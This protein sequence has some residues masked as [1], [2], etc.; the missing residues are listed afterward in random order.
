MNL[1]DIPNFG[2]GKDVN[3]YVKHILALVHGGILWMD[4]HVSIDVDF[5]AEII[6]LPIDGEKPEHYL[7]DITK[8]KT[9]GE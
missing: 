3:S 8:K 2:R 4:M 9:L 6:G 7:D 5:I 1:L